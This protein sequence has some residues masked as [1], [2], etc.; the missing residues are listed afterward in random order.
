MNCSTNGS[1]CGCSTTNSTAA[2]NTAPSQPASPTTGQTYRPPANVVESA[3]KYQVTLDVPGSTPEGIDVQLHEGILS[4]TAKVAPR[5]FDNARPLLREFGV[6][7][8]RR[9]FRVGEDIE[10]AAISAA[11]ASGVLTIE[12]PKTRKPEARRVPV[13]AN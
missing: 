4:V 5:S 10:P 13:S 9:Q 7:D 1:S 12:L 11:Y 6:G 8:F 2:A 3:D